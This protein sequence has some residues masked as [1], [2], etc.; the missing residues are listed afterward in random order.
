MQATGSDRAAGYGMMLV[1]ALIFVYYTMWVIF[2]VSCY[3]LC[4]FISLSHRL[5]LLSSLIFRFHSFGLLSYI[6]VIETFQE[7][8]VFINLRET[9]M[10]QF[11]QQ[12]KIL[13]DFCFDI[14]VTME[15][16]EGSTDF[17]EGKR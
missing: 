6:C 14:S 12:L 3:P 11:S 5:W 4:K 13:P 16:R 15:G 17:K 1:S 7:Q 9:T 10:K 2:L 8:K